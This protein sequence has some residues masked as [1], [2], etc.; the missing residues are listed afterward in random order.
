[1]RTLLCCQTRLARRLGWSDSQV[2]RARAPSKLG[3]IS[4]LNLNLNHYY[5]GD[6]SKQLQK[7]VMTKGQNVGYCVICG[8]HGKLTRDHVPP[9]GCNNKTDV[10]LRT[11]LPSHEKNSKNSETP[12][13]GGTNFKTLCEKCNSSPLGDKYDPELINLSNEITKTALAVDKKQI[14]LP[15]VRLIFTRPQKLARAVIGHILAANAVDETKD[16]LRTFDFRDALRHYFLNEKAPLPEEVDIYFWIY[17]SRRQVIIKDAH[18]GSFGNEPFCCHILK[19]LPLGFW[20]LWEKPD[21]FQT[22][23]PNL[24]ADKSMS[25]DDIYQTKVDFRSIPRLDF[26]EMPIDN[27]ITFLSSK[28]IVGNPK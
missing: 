5:M 23:L 27:Q 24:V 2:G 16:G 25:I 12:S 20:V 1:M 11:L 9:K 26:P 3:I 18:I 15:S 28:S 10:V 8:S 14:M 21:T 4:T 7:R 17:P 6:Y 19:F 13:Q 22:T